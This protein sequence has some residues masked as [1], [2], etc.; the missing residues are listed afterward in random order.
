MTRRCGWCGLPLDEMGHTTTVLVAGDRVRVTCSVQAS[1][2][3]RTLEADVHFS[4][5]P[6]PPDKGYN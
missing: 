3:V 4:D 6:D 5:I 1:G 2:Y